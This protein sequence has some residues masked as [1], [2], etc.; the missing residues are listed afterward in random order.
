M[1]ES[2]KSDKPAQKI[3]NNMP[4]L[5]GAITP[6]TE[7]LAYVSYYENQKKPVPNNFNLEP[8]YFKQPGD[9]DKADYAHHIQNNP[10]VN[11]WHNTHA[12][13][14]R[15][16]DYSPEVLTIDSLPVSPDGT[17][18][19]K[20]TLWL[21]L[22]C[23]PRNINTSG[24]HIVSG[25]STNYLAML[26]HLAH[27]SGV[28][29]DEN[30]NNTMNFLNL[31]DLNSL[32]PGDRMPKRLAM[33]STLGLLSIGAL[34]YNKYSKSRHLPEQKNLSKRQ[35]LK[36]GLKAA[37][38]YA[39]TDTLINLK[40]HHINSNEG[41]NA[42]NA[43]SR[44]KK[45]ESLG[46]L[47]FNNGNPEWTPL[48]GKTALLI[49]KHQDAAEYLKNNNLIQKDSP[50]SII[51]DISISQDTNK[52]IRND[53]DRADAILK[54]AKKILENLYQQ[55]SIPY[56]LNRKENYFL[57]NHALDYLSLIE[58]NKINDPKVSPGALSEYLKINSKHVNKFNSPSVEKIIKP[59]RQEIMIT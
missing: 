42:A 8:G 45:D 15:L 35:F 11:Y 51:Y 17:E 30:I 16:M 12:L 6:F 1:K 50:G 36:H 13:Q 56:N 3:A 39:L 29:T 21:M 54:Y 25:D 48:A 14:K 26:K 57:Q 55:I 32:T 7:T 47:F 44:E 23:R 37:V 58:I 18:I 9:V 28:S 20:S 38:S 5:A 24:I 19:K 10:D 53:K 43:N 31:Q 59:L 41:I 2:Y 22:P 33:T 40:K 49:A 52:M 4:Y 46:R 27:N 34:A